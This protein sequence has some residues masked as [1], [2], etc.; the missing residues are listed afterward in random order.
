[1][2]NI[3]RL[4]ARMNYE[5]NIRVPYQD[6][7]YGNY[8]KRDKYEMYMHRAL[9]EFRLIISLDKGPKYQRLWDYLRKAWIQMFDV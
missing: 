1:M 4:I 6:I 3:N 7:Y 2:K 8:D 5:F 9:N